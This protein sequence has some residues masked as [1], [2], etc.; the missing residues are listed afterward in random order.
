VKCIGVF[1]AFFSFLLFRAGSIIFDLRFTFSINGNADKTDQAD[2]YG[3]FNNY[4]SALS[5]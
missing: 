1:V 4:L 5:A 2:V 3:F